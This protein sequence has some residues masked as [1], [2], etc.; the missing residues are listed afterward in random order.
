MS[1]RSDPGFD[2]DAVREDFVA[3]LAEMGVEVAWPDVLDVAVRHC[4]AEHSGRWD[5]GCAKCPLLLVL[6]QLRRYELAAQV[7]PPL[8]QLA[9]A[10][11]RA[12]APLREALG[13]LSTVHEAVGAIPQEVREW[14]VDAGGEDAYRPAWE[15]PMEVCAAMDA[16]RTALLHLERVRVPPE[17]LRDTWIAHGGGDGMR[18]LQWIV[19]SALRE[20][21]FNDRQIVELVPDSGGGTMESRLKR[22]QSRRYENKMRAA[23]TPVKRPSKAR[24]VAQTELR[25]RSDSPAAAVRGNLTSGAAPDPRGRKLRRRRTALS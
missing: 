16:L 13:T 15:A 7:A 22:L 2:V 1:K 23:G 8:V 17:L 10:A 6:T 18:V 4:D 5:K 20:S 24:K 14:A 11:S 3:R 19:E 9:D 12:L 21:G 25:A